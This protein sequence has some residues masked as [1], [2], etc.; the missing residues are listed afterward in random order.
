MDHSNGQARGETIEYTNSQIRELISEHI[1][2]ARDRE[3]LYRK[4]IDGA[5]YE[6]IAMEIGMSPRQVGD[7]VRRETKRLISKLPENC[8]HIAC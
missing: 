6:T 1:H 5:G 3:I 2:S 7:I 8:L 4:L